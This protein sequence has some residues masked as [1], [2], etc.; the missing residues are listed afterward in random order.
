MKRIVKLALGLAV[1]L[2]IIVVSGAQA[3]HA[4][5]GAEDIRVTLGKSVV[6]DYPE[7]V[8]RISTSNPEVVDYVPVSTREILLH[9][10]GLG[11]ATLVIW[12]KSGQRNFYNINVEQNLEPARKLIRDAFPKEDIQVASAKDTI[13][14]TGTVSSQLVVDRLV[15]YITPMAKSVVNNLRVKAG[16]IEKQVMLRVKFAELNRNYSNQFAV[17]LTSLGALNTVGSVGTG[18]F[19]SI[20]AN[21]IG[22]ENSFSITDALNVFAFRPD[23]NLAAFVKLLQQQGMLQILAEPNLIT[24]NG[25]EASFLV[26]GEFPVPVLQ[27]GANS[28][29]VT[30][31]FREYGIRLTFNPTLTEN[32]TLKMYVKPEVSTI[33]LANA[34]SVS[35]FVIPALAT[36]RVES[37][38]E[39]G[40]GQSF[41]IGG[42]V[43]DRTNEVFA[44]MP[45]LANIPLLGQLFKSRNENRQ[46]TELIV[47]VTPE[48][49]EPLNAADQK[50]MPSL[51]GGFLNP[52]MLPNGMPQSSNTGSGA[53]IIKGDPA[54]I[55]K[56]A[57]K[58]T[59]PVK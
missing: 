33:D 23:L 32:G 29:A 56:D 37:T 36:R 8:N 2:A 25:K 59:A 10:K 16:P 43:D 12:A 31:Q 7:D 11:A 5:G 46:K 47:L 28:G 49:V 14:I 40:P 19:G 35:G 9:A 53:K 30:I 3:L 17:N 44:K 39:L 1:G 34:V 21:S 48:F 41:I 15:A 50:L 18:Q 54:Q 38:I 20:K 24:S 26:G 6:I 13:S 27:G 51:P 22:G 52:M 4:Q 42:L 58:R 55:Q 45:G 57:M